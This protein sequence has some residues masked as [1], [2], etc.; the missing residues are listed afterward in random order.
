MHLG[1]EKKGLTWQRF[2]FRCLCLAKE[3]IS[4]KRSKAFW[5]LLRAKSIR[6]NLSGFLRYDPGIIPPEITLDPK[7]LLDKD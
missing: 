3:K 5:I 6:K 7:A 4:F 2:F 1:V